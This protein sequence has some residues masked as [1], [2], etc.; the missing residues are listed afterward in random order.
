M[1]PFQSW[2][3]LPRPSE[4]KTKSV[5][6]YTVP[7]QPHPLLYRCLS[8]ADKNV[9]TQNSCQV[10]YS[11]TSSSLPYLLH[12][13]VRYSCHLLLPLDSI[14]AVF[15]W[16]VPVP[17]HQQAHFRGAGEASAIL[18]ATSPNSPFTLPHPTLS[19]SYLS[20]AHKS[21]ISLSL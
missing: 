4:R 6:L 13:Q 7:R 10:K 17:R 19:L 14:V 20:E 15:Q 1:P 18:T 21:F 5:S 11:S 12:S 9:K 8:C 3:Y 16:P 2:I